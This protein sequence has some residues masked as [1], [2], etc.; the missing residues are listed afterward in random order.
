LPGEPGKSIYLKGWTIDREKFLAIPLMS[1][2]S[3]GPTL[4]LHGLFEQFQNDVD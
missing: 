1:D 3:R 4:E 2:G